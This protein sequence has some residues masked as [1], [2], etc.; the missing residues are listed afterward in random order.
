MQSCRI[1]CTAVAT[2]TPDLAVTAIA[3]VTA[4]AAGTVSAAAAAKT[5]CASCAAVANVV[6]ITA[7]TSHGFQGGNSNIRTASCHTNSRCIT[8][9][10]RAASQTTAQRI[11][12]STTIWLC[13]SAVSSIDHCIRIHRMAFTASAA[14]SPGSYFAC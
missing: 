12:T 2:H 7:T 1:A 13:T 10:A 14:N 4:I 5:T 8:I 3:S 9:T 11:L 6:T